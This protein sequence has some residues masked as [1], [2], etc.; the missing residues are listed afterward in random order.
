MKKISEIE[1]LSPKQQIG[2]MELLRGGQ[3]YKEISRKLGISTRTLYNWRQDDRFR[4]AVE[5]V[6]QELKG[7][8]LETS[9]MVVELN[10]LS[11]SL[12]KD[13]ELTNYAYLGE[14]LN[15]IENY[16]TELREIMKILV[17]ALRELNDDVSEIKEI[18]KGNGAG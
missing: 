6:T 16:H 1:A 5:Q 15:T 9:G 10:A 8:V 17:K 2:A 11:N 13:V 3:T 4:Q 7:K 18:T 12:L 14:R